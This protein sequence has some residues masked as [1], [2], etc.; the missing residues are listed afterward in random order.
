M[1]ITANLPDNPQ[2]LEGMLEGLVNA[3]AAEIAAGLVPPY[4][5]DAGVKYVEEKAGA[6]KWKL[7]HEVMSDGQGDCED[8]ASWE[9]AGMRVTGE[10]PGARVRLIKTGPRKLHAVVM[11]SDGAISD[12][13]A[14]LMVQQSTESRHKHLGSICGDCDEG[15]DIGAVRVL[16]RDKNFVPPPR[17]AK[18][19][20]IPAQGKEGVRV[21]P[22][23][24]ETLGPG[25]IRRTPP[26]LTDQGFGNAAD[27]YAQT[28]YY[29]PGYLPPGWDPTSVWGMPGGTVN[30]Y[31]YGSPYN[32]S[33]QPAY[34]YSPDYG[35]YDSPYGWMY[36]GE[37]PLVS[38][39][40]LYGG[41]SFGPMDG[42]FGSPGDALEGRGDALEVLQAAL[43][44]L[45]VFD[46]A[47]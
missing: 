28:P 32:Y 4:P 33:M 35:G 12:V 18:G 29:P 43:E 16:S 38:Y 6:E 27:P 30:P 24:G 10:D 15:I 17:G 11:R 45:G 5:E 7:P 44:E 23:T 9:C 14:R 36:Q 39:E 42:P 26:H 1:Q 25:S 19:R 34:G 22:M 47:Q 20:T 21:D 3:A 41:A 8:L 31:D 13:C 46:G 37:S 40:D 2:L